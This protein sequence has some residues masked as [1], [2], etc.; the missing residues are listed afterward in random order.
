MGNNTPK[1]INIRIASHFH[2]QSSGKRFLEIGDA[3]EIIQMCANVT[4][5]NDN[6]I[7]KVFSHVNSSSDNEIL[8]CKD[9]WLKD[10]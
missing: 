8:H 9:R 10:F 7:L 3:K 6:L 5:G 4:T 1:S 2:S